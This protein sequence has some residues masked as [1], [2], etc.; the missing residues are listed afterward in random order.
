MKG[1]TNSASGTK[2]ISNINTCA[3]TIEYPQGY[4]C[5]LRQNT[6]EIT[7]P[8]GG[9]SYTF[10]VD[11]G[12][13]EAVCSDGIF[14]Y[15][16]SVTVDYGQSTKLILG[17]FLILESPSTFTLTPGDGTVAGKDGTLEYSTNG[18]T[19]TEWDELTVLTAG[20]FHDKYVLYL[21][22]T[23]NTTLT[24]TSGSVG[25]KGW[26][27]AGSNISVKGNIATLLD[28]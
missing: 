3:I 28:W 14:E 23:G 25:E 17:K 15:K 11:Y 6:R 13:W 7:A 22:G 26:H 27:L 9:T 8:S 21:R 1:H 16:D 10:H 5:I 19:W 2:A 18:E 24:G 20:A 12:T 4:S